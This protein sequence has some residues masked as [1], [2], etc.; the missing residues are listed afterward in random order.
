MKT[1]TIDVHRALLN[2]DCKQIDKSLER[3]V[4]SVEQ[5]SPWY[6]ESNADCWDYITTSETVP[7]VSTVAH[8]WSAE[9]GCGGIHLHFKCPVCGTD[10]YGDDDPTDN[11]PYLWYAECCVDVILVECSNLLEVRGEP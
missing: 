9:G 6:T 10:R 1:A 5:D 7:V 2:G 3:L 8:D 11:L 4:L